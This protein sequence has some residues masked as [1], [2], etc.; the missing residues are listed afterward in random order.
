MADALIDQG[1]EVVVICSS[2]NQGNGRKEFRREKII[3]SPAFRMKKKT[4]MARLMN[5]MSFGVSSIFSSLKAGKADIVITTSPPPLV[6]ISGWIIAKLKRAKLVYDVR[7]IWPDVALE[8]GSFSEDC[9]F[10]KIFRWIALFM[11]KNADMI[12]TVSPGKVAK[13][14]EYVKNIKGRKC[15]S[16][17][18]SK[19]RLVGNGFDE[20]VEN[21]RINFD[22]IRR[23]DL[24]HIFTCVY[25]GNIGLAQG[26]GTLLKLAAETKHKEVQFL[27]FGMGAEKEIL[28][29]KVREMGLDNVKFCGVLPH[30]DVYTLLS[31][32][33]L[34]F[35]SLKNSHMKDSIPTKVY[36]ALGIG[37]PVL[38]VA[39]GDSC[40]IVEEAKLGRCVSPDH[41]EH[42]AG[43]FDEM[44]DHYD[45]IIIHKE[46]AK[47]LMHDQYSRQQI[48][49]KF[50][51]QL[52]DF[53]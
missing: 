52:R 53:C 8:M 47:R 38:L 13:I 25:V 41:V 14:Q 20:S 21:H 32:A 12:T 15:G 45:Q 28:E 4:T 6:S 33:K 11:Y 1:N 50:E 35:I 3:Y 19:V 9:A 30:E 18:V 31:F 48:A 37:C 36:E 10:C 42:L 51:K 29:E 17:N 49:I 27:L 7:D 24:D 39:E 23:Y 43:V 46:A 16:I 26:L 2:A 40:K 5:N 44:I 22:L 34:S